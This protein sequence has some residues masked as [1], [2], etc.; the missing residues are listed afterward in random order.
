M[1][2]N[3]NVR[4]PG[5]GYRFL[6]KSLFCFA[7]AVILCS[8]IGSFVQAKVGDSELMTTG[9]AIAD[10]AQA[11]FVHWDPPRK[12]RYGY[13]M[14]GRAD[15]ALRWY[16][17]AALDGDARAIHNVGLM[18]IT[19]E[20]APRDSVEGARWLRQSFAL[21]V[22]ESGIALGDM[23]RLGLGHPAD[24]ARALAYY[25]DAAD[26]GESRAMHALGNMHALGLG[27]AVAPAEALF[28]YILSSDLGHPQAAA[29]RD[30]LT[31]ALP[32]ARRA[33]VEARARA[34]AEE[35]RSP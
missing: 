15:I 9:C 5:A 30:A 21:G 2:F 3:S 16:R 24:P 34:W 11:P 22:A 14:T 18:L 12:I 32:P 35:R 13:G 27:V 25:R 8:A 19:G 1:K 17:K 26:R 23:A 6:C 4:G 20:G 33:A 10:C 28:W 31:A 29:A 7:T